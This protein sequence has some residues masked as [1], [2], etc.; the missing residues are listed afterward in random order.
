MINFA[1]ESRRSRRAREQV[2]LVIIVKQR[3]VKQT[4]ARKGEDL[5]VQAIGIF[6]IGSKY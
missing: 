6:I 4:I 5:D 1:Q 2:D 3:E